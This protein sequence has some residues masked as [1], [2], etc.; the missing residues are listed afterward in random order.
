MIQVKLVRHSPLIVF[1]REAITGSI[2]PDIAQPS[3]SITRQEILTLISVLERFPQED[4]L[5]AEVD[6]NQSFPLMI[7][8]EA[9]LPPLLATS[10][11]KDTSAQVASEEMPAVVQVKNPVVVGKRHRPKWVNA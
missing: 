2:Y 3:L 5:G 9:E 11:Q 6:P 8:D 10:Y 4:M 7:V 1:R